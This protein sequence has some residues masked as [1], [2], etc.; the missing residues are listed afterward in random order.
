[1]QRVHLLHDVLAACA[2]FLFMR[3]EGARG[4]WGRGEVGGGRGRL[5]GKRGRL[6][7][8]RR[9]VDGRKGGKGEAVRRK[10]EGWLG[11]GVC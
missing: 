10:G 7:G 5:V 1:M 3:G 4:C 9:Q 8:E 6:V 11:K 2:V